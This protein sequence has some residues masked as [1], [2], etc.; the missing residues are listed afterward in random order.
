MKQENLVSLT[1]GVTFSLIR[2]G[3][4][5]V[6]KRYLTGPN[7]EYATVEIDSKKYLV[8]SG[9]LLI[10]N[11]LGNLSVIPKK[12]SFEVE[13]MIREKCFRCLDKLVSSLNRI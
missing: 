4:W 3:K 2:L 7:V 12:F 11:N 6:V 5:K 13:D 10:K 8:E 9:Q 1:A